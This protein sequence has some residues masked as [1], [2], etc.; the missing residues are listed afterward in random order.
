MVPSP[1]ISHTLN[2]QHLSEAWQG[3]LFL[4]FTAYFHVLPRVF[5]PSSSAS[6]CFAGGC[7]GVGCTPASLPASS[8][9]PAGQRQGPARCLGSRK[10]FNLGKLQ[11][12]TPSAVKQLGTMLAPAAAS[13]SLISK[14]R[15]MNRF[16]TNQSFLQ[17]RKKRAPYSGFMFTETLHKSRASLFLATF[18][19][20][21]C[22]ICF[23][24]NRST[25]NLPPNAQK[26]HVFGSNKSYTIS[27]SP[28][29]HTSY[30]HFRRSH[31]YS[32]VSE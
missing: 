13:S 11:Q 32:S 19:T 22:T 4:A 24:A 10:S 14:R 23:R 6:V 21:S 2:T 3:T 25:N 30:L 31:P 27:I 15:L 26:L 28:Y 12:Q 1:R 29:Q 7:R 17:S 20:P 5:F 18:H 16:V 8:S 9:P